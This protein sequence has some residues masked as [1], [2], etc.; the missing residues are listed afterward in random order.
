ML[1]PWLRAWHHVSVLSNC[2]GQ[3]IVEI[4]L[5]TPLLLI[6]LYIPVDFGI[7]LFT[8]HLTQ[9]AVREATRIGVSTKDPFNSTAATAIGNEALNR[10]PA[11]L[12]SPSV[13]VRYFTT[14]AVNCMEN[15]EVRAQGN[16]NFF[17]YRLM[18]MFG[19]TVSPS[20]QI[21]RATKMWYEFQSVTNGTGA[22][23]QCNT[24]TVT[25]TVPVS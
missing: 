19:F 1:D 12:T 2:K 17:L 18:G 15:V 20:I 13:T 9:N 23:P 3:S 22:T 4:A 25:A 6:T 8:A 5:I 16:Y 11:R 21:T 10:L 7:G 24:A 14:G